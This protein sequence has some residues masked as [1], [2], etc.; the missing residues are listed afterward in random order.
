MIK[1]LIDMSRPHMLYACGFGILML[2]SLVGSN[3]PDLAF[4]GFVDLPFRREICAGMFFAGATLGAWALQRHLQ[5]ART[6][7]RIPQSQV[8]LPYTGFFIL[9][10]VAI[11]IAH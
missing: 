11:A 10:F 7:W 9:T 8:S 6:P 2:L 4:S 1:S 3:V 5:R